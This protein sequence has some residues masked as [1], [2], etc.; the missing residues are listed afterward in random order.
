MKALPSQE[1][2]DQY[3]AGGDNTTTTAA[4]TIEYLMRDKARMNMKHEEYTHKIQTQAH[5]PLEYSVRYVCIYTLHILFYF[6]T[7]YR[8]YIYI[9]TMYNRITN[10]M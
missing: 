3:R 1:E 10:H 8:I 4:S 5:S 2:V 7:I 9:L 6:Y